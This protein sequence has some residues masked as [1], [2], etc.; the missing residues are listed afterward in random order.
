VASEALAEA[1]QSPCVIAEPGAFAPLRD[2]GGAVHARLW[3][4]LEWRVDVYRRQHL[5]DPKR[6]GKDVRHDDH[7][8]RVWVR[9]LFGVDIDDRVQFSLVVDVSRFSSERL[10]AMLLAAAGGEAP[11]D[12]R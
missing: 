5:V 12:D 3:A 1:A 8:K 7:M 6:A 9:T 11:A 4:P 2:R 10:V